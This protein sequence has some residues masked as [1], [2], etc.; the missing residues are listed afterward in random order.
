MRACIGSNQGKVMSDAST[1]K[2]LSGRCL[3]GNVTLG[4]K[5]VSPNVGACHCSMCVTWTGG[6][7]LAVDCHQD[8][9]LDGDS[10]AVFESSAWAERGFCSRC[11]THLF[12]KIKQSGQYIVPVGLFKD[13]GDFVFDH[14]IFVDEKPQYYAF[15]NATKNM[16]GA[17]V[18][19]Q[20]TAES[21]PE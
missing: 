20:F 10:V 14:Q 11:G 18:F 2:S 8:V 17:E 7:L 12:Y 21:G 19:A 5:S 15:A 3:C 6:P 4:A 1:S 13:D 9:S 16:T